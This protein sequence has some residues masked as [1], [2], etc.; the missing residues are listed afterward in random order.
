MNKYKMNQHGRLE[1]GAVIRH[2]SIELCPLGVVAFHFF[3]RWHMENEPSPEFTSR[4]DWYDT[5]V[6]KGLVRTKPITYNTQRNGYMEAFN[7]VGV[8]SSKIAHI[9]RKSAFRVV[10]DQDVPD[11][12]QR[13]IGRWGL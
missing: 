9:N 2:G 5:H 7:A 1:Y 8:N 11:N 10:A 4:Q 6:L 12:E 3:C 13:R